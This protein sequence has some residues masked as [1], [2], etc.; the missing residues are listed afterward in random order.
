MLEINNK[1]GDNVYFFLNCFFIYSFLGWIFECI[2]MSF[3]EKTIVTNR[4]FIRG[5]LCTIY[6]VGALGA[7]FLFQPI[8]HNRLMLF[9]MGA[10][11]ATLFEMLVG[12]L[13]MKLFGEL[14][15]NYDN[16]RFNYKGVIC[17]ESSV[18]WGVMTML[19]FMV[20]QPFIA[21]FVSLYFDKYGERAVVIMLVAYLLDFITSFYKATAKKHIEDN[22][23]YGDSRA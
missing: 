14:W 21:W 3:E 9:I 10:V 22:E 13:M 15:W 20:F 4:G 2:V 23:E 18:C 16:K 17:L 6:G 8:A 5:P 12:K 1:I 7:Y 11:V 19:T